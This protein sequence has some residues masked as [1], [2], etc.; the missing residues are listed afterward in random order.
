MDKKTYRVFVQL[1]EEDEYGDDF[2]VVSEDSILTTNDL[3][4]ATELFEW[5]VDNA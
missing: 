1:E 2:R 4:E 5:V 3:Q